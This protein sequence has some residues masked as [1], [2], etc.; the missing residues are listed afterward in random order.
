MAA[1]VG[2]ESEFL[3]DDGEFAFG[4]MGGEPGEPDAGVAF[5]D[6]ATLEEFESGEVLHRLDAGLKAA[7]AG[8]DRSRAVPSP[9]ARWGPCDG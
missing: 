4:D 1:F 2:A 5:A 9:I 8:G 3:A 7:A 6:G